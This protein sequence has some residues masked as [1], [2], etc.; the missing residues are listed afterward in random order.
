LASS[1]A[2]D[3]PVDPC[4][5]GC[6]G[7]ATQDLALALQQ[8]AGEARRCYNT[9]LSTD[10]R[11]EGKVLLA[12][13]VAPDGSVCSS[14]LIQSEMPGDMNACLEELFAHATFPGPTGGCVDARV[15]ML[16]KP[17]SADAGP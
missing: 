4:K 1:Q 15:P 5:G 12:V 14:V 10:P 16:F 17:V 7:K 2:I 13:R 3:A 8:K 9:A 6:D 11:V